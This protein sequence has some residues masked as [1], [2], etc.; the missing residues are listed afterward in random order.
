VSTVAE[1]PVQPVRRAA[2]PRRVLRAD[3][4]LMIVL[5]LAL[6]LAPLYLQNDY[7]VRILVLICI[8]GAASTGWNLLGGFANQISLGHAV[9]FGVGAYA[10]VILQSR[11][12]LSPWV[13]MPVG[14][15]VSLLAALLIGWPTFRL[16]GHY[17]ALGTLALLQIFDIVAR[18]WKDLTGGPAGVT[19]P[20]LPSSLLN[21]QF[22]RTGPYLYVAGGL[23]IVALA[24]AWLVR[25]SRLGLRLDCIR[26]NPQAASLAGVNLF[27]TKLAALLIS[28][29]IVSL[30]GSMYA[31]FQ[32]FLDPN[33]AFSFNTSINMALFAIIGGVS[34]WWGPLLGALILVPLGQVAS[35][36]LTGNLAAL[37]PLSYGL[38]LIV[39]VILQPRG[40][41]GWLNALWQRLVVRGKS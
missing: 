39:L 1:R 30:A 3:A 32:G 16:S 35:S 2:R 14:V 40:I 17:F 25:Y 15:L 4:A 41:A 6:F 33:T 19:L 37:G 24:S 9:F 11:L 31:A 10:V 23:L 12:G 34:F 13:A 27:R 38:L 36:Q 20:I 26:L 5:A 18:Y 7:Q 22:D 8:F 28:A 29:V 21:L